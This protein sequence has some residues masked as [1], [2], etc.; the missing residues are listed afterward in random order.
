[1]T[2]SP[3]IAL[4]LE[5]H[6]SV[7]VIMIGGVLYRHSMVNVGAASIDAMSHIQADTFF[8][9]V[10]GVDM[11]TGLTTGDLEEAHIKKALSHRAADTIVLASEEKLE[12]ASSYVV[13]PLNNAS[14]IVVDS[15]T[16]KAL[17]SRIRKKG[18][19]IHMP[20]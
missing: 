11:K 17:I 4:A 14:G 2:H 6:Q 19:E 15:N 3:A 9:G 10:T 13:M 8:M 20:A 1:M 18:L 5:H 12:V 7:Q 16:S